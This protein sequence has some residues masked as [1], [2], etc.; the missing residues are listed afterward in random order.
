MLLSPAM[1]NAVL[2]AT[3]ICT[4]SL[5]YSHSAEENMFD[6]VRQDESVNKL[7][8]ILVN[9]TLPTDPL[10]D[11]INDKLR[12]GEIVIDTRHTVNTS[13]GNPFTYA[14]LK[15][16]NE[17]GT[18]GTANN[19]TSDSFYGRKLPREI[20]ISFVLAM[21][22]YWWLI[23]LERILP[24]RP[25]YRD[26]PARQKDQVEESEDREEEVVKKWI[27]QGRVHRASLNWRNT[28]LKWLLDLTIGLLCV[29]TVEHMLRQ[30]LKLKSP[31][32]IFDDL[33]G[34][35]SYPYF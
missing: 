8:S 35:S 6:K 18:N 3:A 12:I 14:T 15:H 25:R 7:L 34:V 17:T 5:L 28:F 11:S 13:Y 19:S 32:L 20:V 29:F 10:I 2:Q 33:D 31:M 9:G 30:T 27:A 22:Q 23:G 24:T 26:V 21:L 1:R 4:I 16:G